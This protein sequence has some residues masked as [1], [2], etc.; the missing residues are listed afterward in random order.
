MFKNLRKNKL[1]LT[2]VI[3]LAVSLVSIIIAFAV[4]GALLSDTV[5][6]VFVSIGGIGLVVSIIL[7]L[8]NE[9]RRQKVIA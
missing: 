9:K 2:S 7:M 4:G 8:I 1:V 6:F 5:L 3:L